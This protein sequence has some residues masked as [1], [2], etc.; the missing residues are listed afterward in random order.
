[1][2]WIDLS[3]RYGRP[4]KELQQQIT[5]ADF[6]ELLAAERLNPRGEYRADLRAAIATAV[7]AEVNRDP[8]KRQRPFTHEDFM[9]QFGP[10]EVEEQSEEQMKAFLKALAGSYPSQPSATSPSSSAPRPPN[11]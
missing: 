9:P 8:K 11:S 10:R 2:F 3:Y 5:S 7:L 4:V 6:A 1:M